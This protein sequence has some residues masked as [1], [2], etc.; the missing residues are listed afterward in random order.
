MVS[1]VDATRWTPL[2][3]RLFVA[4]GSIEN[5][6]HTCVRAWVGDVIYK[7][8]A[9]MPLS[10]RLDLAMDLGDAQDA[11]P[12]TKQS[13]RN[14]LFWAKQLVRHR[15]LVAHNPLCLVLLQEDPPLDQPLLEAIAHASEDGKMISFEELVE[16][17][18]EA[19]Q[20]ADEVG[21]CH[22]MFRIEK[23]DFDS[24]RNSEDVG[25]EP[26]P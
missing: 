21:R 12:A 5:T 16:V 26:H 13:F 20:C 24:L 2:I 18:V 9:R 3:G 7:H 4:F 14:A 15:N 23:M 22:A 8:V 6:T 11:Q 17:V 10:A 1:L 19:E 25:Q